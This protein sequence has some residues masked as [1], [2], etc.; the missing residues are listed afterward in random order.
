MRHIS[1]KV[2]QKNNS[3]HS[4]RYIL[5]SV[6]FKERLFLEETRDMSDYISGLDARMVTDSAATCAPGRSALLLF[7]RRAHRV[8]GRSSARW[9][10]AAREAG[11]R[12]GAAHERG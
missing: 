7:R 10:S 8:V 9:R 12:G 2:Q 6:E 4:I 5:L 11:P 3:R 1:V